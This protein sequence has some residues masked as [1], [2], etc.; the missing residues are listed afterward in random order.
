M[1]RH[2]KPSQSAAACILMAVALLAS[3]GC[4]GSSSPAEPANPTPTPVPH[5][6][7]SATPTPVPARNPILTFAIA[8]SCNDGLGLQVRFF[9]TT[10]GL[11]WPSASSVYTIPSGGSGTYPLSVIIGSTVCFGAET[12]PSNGVY[13]GVGVNNTHSCAAC[14]YTVTHD[15]TVSLPLTCSSGA[16]TPT[17]TPTPSTSPNVTLSWTI[18]DG[19]NEG[20]GLQVRFFD[21]NNNLVWPDSSNAY[22][23]GS[24]Q[25]QTFNLNALRSG[26]ICVGAETNPPN[27]TYWGVD[28]TGT[29]GCSSCCETFPST[30]SYFSQSTSLNC[31]GASISTGASSAHV[32]N[33]PR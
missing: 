2:Q 19:C 12:N 23:I 22:L 9:D 29:Q 24:N 16:P 6:T 17:P 3:G 26:K 32:T 18:T 11:S 10:H 25:Q 1:R 14:C 28:L 31:G 8:D 21:K 5:L 4:G 27:G 7:P 15:M 33:G 30:G 13:W 20:L